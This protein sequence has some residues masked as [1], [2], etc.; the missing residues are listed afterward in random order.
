V[1]HKCRT[2]VHLMLHQRSLI[3]QKIVSETV[4]HEC[5]TNGLFEGCGCVG[6]FISFGSESLPIS[7]MPWDATM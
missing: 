4:A 3:V 1:A 7:A 5:H 6:R 2:L